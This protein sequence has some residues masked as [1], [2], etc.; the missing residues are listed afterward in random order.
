MAGERTAR[1]TAAGLVGP[2]TLYVGIGLLVPLSTIQSGLGVVV[3]YSPERGDQ[4]VLG[5]HAIAD[6]GLYSTCLA[7]QNLWLAATAE[8]L[9][10][11]WVSFYREDFLADLVGLPD[12]VRPVAWLC[13]G[14]VR[15]L[16]AVPDLVRHGWRTGRSLDEAIHLESWRG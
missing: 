8:G 9:G 4:H 3:T 7:I 1:S 6:T 10:V 15:H 14:P 16:Q 2:A 13:L 11:G 5:R 12:G